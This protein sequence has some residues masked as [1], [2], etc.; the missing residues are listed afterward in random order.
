MANR[1]NKVH[2]WEGDPLMVALIAFGFLWGGAQILIFI[3][4]YDYK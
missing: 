4:T 3:L 2:W 1:K